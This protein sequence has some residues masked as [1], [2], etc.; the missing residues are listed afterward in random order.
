M[1]LDRF[2]I[3]RL[4]QP[5]QELAPAFL[6][7]A[8]PVHPVRAQFVGQ[9]QLAPTVQRHDFDDHVVDVLGLFLHREGKHEAPRPV[10]LEI[11]ADVLDVLAVSPIHEGEFA[12]DL[13][14][15]LRAYHLPGC[16]RE[17]EFAGLLGV[18]SGVE[19]T[20]RRRVEAAT[21]VANDVRFVDHRDPPFPSLN[22]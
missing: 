11:F 8:L 12:A 4:G 15:D 1:I 6:D 17:Q 10:D 9:R 5:V 19:D 20:L 3:D 7:T 22:V 14:I 21:D 13:G 16:R 18:E 2:L